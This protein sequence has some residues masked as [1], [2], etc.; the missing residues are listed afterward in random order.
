MTPID[1]VMGTPIVVNSIAGFQLANAV[2]GTF[3]FPLPTGVT[4][5]IPASD[6]SATINWGDGSAT[7]AGTI[8]LAANGTYDVTGTHIYATPGLFPTSLTIAYGGSTVTIPSP[9]GFP[10]TSP[11]NITLPATTA[12]STSSSSVTNAPLAVTAYPITRTEALPIAP[13]ST[14]IASFID[15]GGPQRAIRGDDRW[16]ARTTTTRC[17]QAISRSRRSG[18]RRHTRSRSAARRSRCLK[19]ALTRLRSLS[20]RPSAPLPRTQ[21]RAP[22]WR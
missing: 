14:I 9:P 13:T 17:R 19:R 2:V 12:S 8:T 11:V 18:V 5:L 1:P 16:P 7:T 4:Q 21:L 22:L 20:R 3:T 6:F 15:G 10:L